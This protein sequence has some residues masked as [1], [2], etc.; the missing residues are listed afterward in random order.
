MNVLTVAMVP[1]GTELNKKFSS[2]RLPSSVN[3]MLV[4]MLAK[5]GYVLTSTFIFERQSGMKM[6]LLQMSSLN[7]LRVSS[8]G[9]PVLNFLAVSVVAW[10]RLISAMNTSEI[11]N[12]ANISKK[13]GRPTRANSTAT[14]P[15][16]SCLKL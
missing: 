3:R 5:S 16:A 7:L 4:S 13:K 14:T 12:I 9:C 15:L 1:A 6:T 8:P 2:F 11:S 10:V